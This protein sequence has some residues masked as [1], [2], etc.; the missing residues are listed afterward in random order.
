MARH[1]VHH[2]RG[3]GDAEARTAK[4]FRH[5]D[6]KPSAVG[7]GAVKPGWKFAVVVALQPILVVEARHH[8]ADALPDGVEMRLAIVVGGIAWRHGR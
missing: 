5:R 4:L 7:H 8:G 6:P 1:F 2:D 3:F